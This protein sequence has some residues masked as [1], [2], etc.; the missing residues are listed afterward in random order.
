MA[1]SLGWLHLSDL[2]FL[3][4][5]DW[6]D[7]AVLRNLKSDISSKKREGLAIDLVFCTGDIGFGETSKE[8]LKD[9]YKIA[10]S[11]FD[12]VLDICELKPDRFF[13]VPGSKKGS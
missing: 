7:S 10:K 3:S 8:P 9:Q 12:A 5:N 2:H 4:A 1:K 6:R 11:F 13:L